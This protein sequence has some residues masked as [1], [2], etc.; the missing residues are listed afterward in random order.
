MFTVNCWNRGIILTIGSNGPPCTHL[1]DC[2]TVEEKLLRQSRFPGV[3]MRDN[4]E[5]SPPVNLGGRRAPLPSL[6][7]CSRRNFRKFGYLNEMTDGGLEYSSIALCTSHVVCEV[8]RSH[9]SVT[10]LGSITAT[11]AAVLTAVAV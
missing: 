2:T 4:G 11:G 1:L 8:R 5:V 3:R 9:V 10:F 6:A 7:R